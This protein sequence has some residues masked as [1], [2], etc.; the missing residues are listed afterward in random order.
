MD[1]RTEGER[2]RE[3]CGTCADAGP[4]LRAGFAAM[5][6][7]RHDRVG[8][9]GPRH[10]AG[11]LVFLGMIIALEVCVDARPEGALNFAPPPAIFGAGRAS[12]FGLSWGWSDRESGV[13]VERPHSQWSMLAD[14]VR[15]AGGGGGGGGGGD[16]GGGGGVGRGGSRE[17]PGKP[18]GSR[19]GGLRKTVGKVKEGRAG[20]GRSTGGKGEAAKGWDGRVTANRRGAAD[21]ELAA[22][23]GKVRN[24]GGA[25]PLE[26]KQT[27]SNSASR[28]RQAQPISSST[29]GKKTAES[30]KPKPGSGKAGTSK[31]GGGDDFMW[32]SSAEE[33]LL[34][35]FGDK[36]DLTLEDLLEEGDKGEDDATKGKGVPKG[37][38]DARDEPPPAPGGGLSTDKLLGF[39]R[40][41][42]TRIAGLVKG[43]TLEK[44]RCLPRTACAA[45]THALMASQAPSQQCISSAAYLCLPACLPFSLPPLNTKP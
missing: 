22:V 31:G 9:R 14:R 38:K 5:Q 28:R 20:A 44:L 43:E 8:V 39:E 16:G 40:N 24:K 30:P 17:D 7:R 34:A 18:S 29:Q 3:I 6:A 2:D 45:C 27:E 35:A 25:P 15:A 19:I 10:T 21:P 12:S 13:V 42:H 33:Q 23:L 36:L 26:E 1:K 37:K 32:S 4:L 41:G 11:I